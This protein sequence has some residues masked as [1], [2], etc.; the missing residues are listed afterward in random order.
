[1]TL[2]VSLMMG[3]L[4]HAFLFFPNTAPAPVDKNEKKRMREESRM[5]DLMEKMSKKKK[6]KLEKLKVE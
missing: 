5:N 4:K 2:R 6:Q 3:N 1:M